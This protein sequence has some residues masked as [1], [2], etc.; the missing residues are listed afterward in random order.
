[1][2]KMT[3]IKKAS[4]VYR[5]GWLVLIINFKKLIVFNISEIT[6][7]CVLNCTEAMEKL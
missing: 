4:G 3:K 2:T 6:Y 7:I 5:K 1:M